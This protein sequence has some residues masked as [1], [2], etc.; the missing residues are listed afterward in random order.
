MRLTSL[1]LLVALP[2][3]AVSAGCEPVVEAAPPPAAP[4]PVAVV[5]IHRPAQAA[6]RNLMNRNFPL[7]SCTASI[8]RSA[9]NAEEATLAANGREPCTIYV[10]RRADNHWVVFVR[11]GSNP[12]NPQA[13]VVV[14]PAG[15]RVQ[16]VDY[17]R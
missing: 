17:L 14:I 8:A 5:D 3:L 10:V 11:S 9:A 15:D 1:E 13:R 7:D 16:R 12:Q 6:I 4:P 2:L